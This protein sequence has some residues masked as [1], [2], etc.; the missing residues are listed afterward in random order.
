MFQHFLV[1]SFCP[2][3]SF[4]RCPP[5]PT[6]NFLPTYR[7]HAEYIR[8]QW[9]LPWPN[10]LVYKSCN[11]S[12]NKTVSEVSSLTRP[13]MGWYQGCGDQN[14]S[15]KSNSSKPTGTPEFKVTLL[16]EFSWRKLNLSMSSSNHITLLFSPSLL[17]VHLHQN[18]SN[19]SICLPYPRIYKCN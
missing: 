1:H 11:S 10:E 19:P 14:F 7:S 13:K 8:H 12:L 9:A 18:L 16:P 4:Q 5:S 3:P 17:R 15:Q 6:L 2:H